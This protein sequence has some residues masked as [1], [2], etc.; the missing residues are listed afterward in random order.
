MRI[1]GSI[2][3]ALW[4]DRNFNHLSDQGRLLAVY[5]LTCPHGNLLGCFRLPCG[6]VCEDLKWELAKVTQ[7]FQELIDAH[8]VKYDA[9]S[10]W[11][12]IIHFLKNNPIV[13]FNQGRCV[14]K[15]CHQR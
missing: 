13:N 8:L 6:F 10:G 14:E 11:V 7:A 3:T 4:F 9:D 1:Y 15:L 5:L 2:Q 12:S